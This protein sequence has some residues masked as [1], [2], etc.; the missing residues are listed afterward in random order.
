MFKFYKRRAISWLTK[1]L[2]AS[3]TDSSQWSSSL[4][5]S[6]NFCN[7]NFLDC[8]SFNIIKYEFNSIF[9]PTFYLTK[10]ILRTLCGQWARLFLWLMIPSKGI[11]SLKVNTFLAIVDNSKPSFLYKLS[12]STTQDLTREWWSAVRLVTQ[13]TDWLTKKGEMGGKK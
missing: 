3:Q 13:I 5:Q 6:V 4:S 10:T 7:L 8:C 9:G 11:N 2:L 12:P 1:R